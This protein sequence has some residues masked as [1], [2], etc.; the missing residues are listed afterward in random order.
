MP[1]SMF[2]GTADELIELVKLDPG[3]ARMVDDL[4]SRRYAAS[5]EQFVRLLWVLVASAV[6]AGA[7]FGLGEVTA[8]LGKKET[9]A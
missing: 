2:E 1:A 7:K 4:R 6:C 8:E 9:R 5:P 3:L